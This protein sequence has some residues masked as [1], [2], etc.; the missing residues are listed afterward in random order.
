[1]YTF[2]T[3][4]FGTFIASSPAF[5]FLKKFTDEVITS[6]KHCEDN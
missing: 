4:G 3:L 5:W 2:Q 6:S 1:M